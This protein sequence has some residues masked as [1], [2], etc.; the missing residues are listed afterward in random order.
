MTPQCNGKIVQFQR[1][2][3]TIIVTGQTSEAYGDGVCFR[4]TI[5]IHQWRDIEILDEVD[6]LAPAPISWLFHSPW[7]IR[8][9]ERSG[10]A[11]EADH[12]LLYITLHEPEPTSFTVDDAVAIPPAGN[13]APQFHGRFEL[14][15]AGKFQVRVRMRLVDRRV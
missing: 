2:D 5:T 14:P 7:P 8:Q 15:A 3:D 11:I 6:L 4:R 9:D 10:I 1:H 12:A 13:L